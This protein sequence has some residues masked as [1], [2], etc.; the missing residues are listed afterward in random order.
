MFFIYIVVWIRTQFKIDLNTSFPTRN[1]Q[2]LNTNE[3]HTREGSSWNY[4]D[5]EGNLGEFMNFQHPII[6]TKK[7]GN[8][9]ACQTM[10]HLSISYWAVKSLFSQT[11]YFKWKNEIDEFNFNHLRFKHYSTYLSLQSFVFEIKI[12]SKAI[13]GECSYIKD[14]RSYSTFQ[15]KSWKPI[16]GLNDFSVANAES[17]TILKFFVKS[18]VCG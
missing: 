8:I 2:E 16:F 1:T 6:S 7:I 4:T 10:K 11:K 14:K 5:L 15:D 17:G 3:L 13:Q 18:L 12:R 9:K